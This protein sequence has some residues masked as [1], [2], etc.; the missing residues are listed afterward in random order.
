[1]TE[2]G[3]GV[4]A[5]P[6]GVLVEVSITRARRRSHRL[7]VDELQP[8][9]AQGGE[10]ECDLA[11]DGTEADDRRT[12]IRKASARSATLL[13]P[14]SGVDRFVFW[15]ELFLNRIP[16]IAL[17]VSFEAELRMPGLSGNGLVM[18]GM[19]GGTRRRD[20]TEASSTRVT[21]SSNSARF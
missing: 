21:S 9:N 3:R 20:R 4:N 6:I 7:G 18:M 12:A 11:A 17:N 2:I 14:P 16:A 8:G 1:V 13:M 5:L 15:H 10:L 19:K